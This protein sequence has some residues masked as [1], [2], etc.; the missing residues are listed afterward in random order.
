MKR[1][2]RIIVSLYIGFV[3][4]SLLV[5]FFGQSG[6]FA[7]QQLHGYHEKLMQN[8]RELAEINRNL[9]SQLESLRSDP[10]LVALYARKLGYF[11]ESEHVIRV[12]GFKTDRN[13]F[14]VGKMIQKPER[15]VNRKPFF[16]T[17][18][19]SIAIVIYLVFG[20][21]RKV[22]YGDRKT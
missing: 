14:S 11:K 8:N 7:L 13:F 19:C 5:L 18:G 15:N 10:E 9:S 21:M 2:V 6:Y 17:F 12:Q 22:R 3:A 16:R 1:G 4:Y 20:I